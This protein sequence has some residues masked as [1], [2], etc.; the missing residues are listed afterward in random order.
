MWAVLGLKPR[1]LSCL[2]ARK[3]AASIG[4]GREAGQ[5]EGAARGAA[6]SGDAASRPASTSKERDH[7][8][9]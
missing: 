1:G 2:R 4:E 6:V 8:R 7:G 3:G 5:T 9:A